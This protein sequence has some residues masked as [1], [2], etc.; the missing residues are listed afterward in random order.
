M[1]RNDTASSSEAIATE[2]IATKA[3]TTKAPTAKAPTT[4]APTV[5]AEPPKSVPTKT[6]GE[7]YRVPLVVPEHRRKLK[8]GDYVVTTDLTPGRKE[9][10]IVLRVKK[11]FVPESSVL[12]E[13]EFENGLPGRTAFLSNYG[14]TYHPALTMHHV[15]TNQQG[16]VFNMTHKNNITTYFVKMNGTVYYPTDTSMK[17]FTKEF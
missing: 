1:S 7:S 13:V 17:G 14:K 5:K 4:K 6:Y 2:A 15:A 12:E 3:P 9:K 10:P 11:V 8:A 16:V